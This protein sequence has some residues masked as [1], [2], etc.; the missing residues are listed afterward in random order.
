MVTS[1]SGLLG[2]ILRPTALKPKYSQNGALFIINLP[3]NLRL[4]ALIFFEWKKTDLTGTGQS[5]FIYWEKLNSSL[6]S[7][8]NVSLE[9]IELGQIIGRYFSLVRWD[10]N[11]HK[12]IQLH[13][14]WTNESFIREL[15][16][17]FLQS[18][19]ICRKNDI[20]PKVVNGKQG[21][22]LARNGFNLD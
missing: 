17:T 8:G 14:C 22:I 7:I 18:Y 21:L 11:C 3:C 13:T 9:W 6:R 16:Y 5:I 15:F 2:N 4:R 20:S 19:T 12:K 10:L 1:I